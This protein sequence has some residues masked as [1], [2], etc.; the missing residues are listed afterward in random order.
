[1]ITENKIKKIKDKYRS[2]YLILQDRIF[3]LLC[4]INLI[5]SNFFYLI[6]L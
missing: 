1:M 5:Y 3:T 4:L 2:T 6:K